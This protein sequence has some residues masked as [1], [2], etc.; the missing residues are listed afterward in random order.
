M[1]HVKWEKYLD[2]AQDQKITT[3]E[4]AGIVTSVT[5]KT[6]WNK[7]KIVSCSFMLNYEQI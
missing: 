5:K 2:K 7:A 1:S 3:G 4:Y 6:K